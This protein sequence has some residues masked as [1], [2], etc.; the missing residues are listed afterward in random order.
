MEQKDLQ[1]PKYIQRETEYYKNLKVWPEFGVYDQHIDGLIPTSRIDSWED[2]HNVVKHY[3][4]DTDEQEFVFRGQQHY[5]WPLLPT[6]DRI[7]KEAIDAS[8]ARKQLR[9]FRLS[10]RG[11]VP[12]NTIFKEDD[13]ELWAIGQHHGLATPLLDWSLSPYVSLFFSF[14]QEDP[15]TWVDIDE[16]ENATPNNFSRVIYVLNKTFIADLVEDDEDPFDKKHP[17]VVEPSKDDHGRLVN[18]A[19]LF[20]FAPYGET[21][22]SSLFK[23]L[24][25][26]DI[27]VNDPNELSK[28]I[29]RI[30]IPNS[31]EVRL[32]CLRHLR[33]MN[34]HHASLFPD[35][36]GASG[37]CNELLVEQTLKTKIKSK[38]LSKVVSPIKEEFIKPLNEFVK[39]INTESRAQEFINAIQ[40]NDAIANNLKIQQVKE[41]ANVVVEFIDVKAGVDWQVRQSELSRLKNIVRRRLKRDYFPDD[42]LK[43]ATEDVVNFALIIDSQ[44]GS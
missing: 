24:V 10:I 41:L 40:T 42:L 15:E 25:D 35:L 11:R 9:N 7:A 29:C 23:A 12:D 2:F 1:E 20:T 30:H 39:S 44:Q 4:Q 3:R 33:K 6:L 5:K 17:K 28:Y 8:L 22:E 34:I 18:Q 26:S 37:Y 19:G 27:D 38:E 21:L 13:E 43:E 32:E 36:I 14:M 16:Q 31:Q